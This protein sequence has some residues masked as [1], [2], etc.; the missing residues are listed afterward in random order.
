MIRILLSIALVVS[1][2][3]PAVAGGYYRTWNVGD[4]AVYGGVP[5]VY[6]VHGW[7]RTSAAATTDGA[8]TKFSDGGIIISEGSTGVVY[9]LRGAPAVARGSAVYDSRPSAG[10]FSYGVN[11]PAYDPNLA[12]KMLGR[13]SDHTHESFDLT[14]NAQAQQALRAQ[15]IVAAQQHTERLKVA[16]G[17]FAD[18]QR[19]VADPAPA[20]ALPVVPDVRINKVLPLGTASASCIK[21]HQSKPDEAPN[22]SLLASTPDGVAKIVGAIVSGKMPKGGDKLDDKQLASVVAD[23]VR[24]AA[25]KNK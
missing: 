20:G 12:L 16:R 17:L 23:L 22:L 3:L 11:I 8:K 2:T 21:C 15:Q 6:T 9:Q 25:V 24:R 14:V 5:Y 7:R 10:S 18:V 4:T 13:M 1:S 19:L